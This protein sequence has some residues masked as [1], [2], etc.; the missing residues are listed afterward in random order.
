MTVAIIGE[1]SFIGS[2]IFERHNENH[3]HVRFFSAR[4]KDRG[5]TNYF[6][7]IDE[8]YNVIY[9]LP[10]IITSGESR[11]FRELLAV[12]TLLVRQLL[13]KIK[14]WNS[15]T[16]FFFPSTR[17]VYDGSEQPLN[18]RSMLNPKSDYAISKYLAECII[19]SEL[20]SE[21]NISFYI[22]R[23]GV[24]YLELNGTR[25][26]IGTLAFMKKGA[27]EEGRINLFGDGQLKRTFTNADDIAIVAE[28]ILTHNLESGI[29]NVGGQSLSL[30]QV[31]TYVA[32]EYQAVVT[33]SPWPES[34]L[35]FESGSTV[36]DSSKLDG[37]IQDFNYK[38]LIN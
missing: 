24:I 2:K 20:S 9:F 1:N 38:A 34:F 12:N 29:Y 18:E 35:K 7:N 32:T 14:S 30:L 6:L 11:N 5:S 8:S 15:Y 4:D 3:D 27:I 13:E 36:F 31:A 16:K 21:A 10:A 22:L 19:Q 17:L 28:K 37:K 26:N 25:E 23:L 33:F